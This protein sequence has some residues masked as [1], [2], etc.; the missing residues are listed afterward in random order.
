M[1]YRMIKA[2]QESI[3]S[4]QEFLEMAGE[5]EFEGEFDSLCDELESGS[6]SSLSLSYGFCWSDDIEVFLV[7]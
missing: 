2:G 1:Q 3:I 4:R 7:K 5:G 6:L